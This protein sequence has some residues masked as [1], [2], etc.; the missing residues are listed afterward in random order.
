M[1]K[2]LAPVNIL[3][4]ATFANAVESKPSSKLELAA[5]S[6]FPKY[7]LDNA[8]PPSYRT[9]PSLLAI[10]APLTKRPL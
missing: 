8:V 3:L 10:R 1:L 4:A 9:A 2:V 5:V 7:L 6:F